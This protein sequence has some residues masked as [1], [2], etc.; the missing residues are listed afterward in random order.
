MQNCDDHGGGVTV[1]SECDSHQGCVKGIRNVCI[2]L[3][4]GVMEM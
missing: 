2:V 3:W 1:V 4:R